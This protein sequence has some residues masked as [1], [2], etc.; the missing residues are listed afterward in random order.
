[1]L[2]TTCVATMLDGGPRHQRPAAAGARANVNCRI[3][4]G[5]PAEEVRQTLQKLVDDPK[6][7][8]TT[9]G[10]RSRGQQR[11]PPPLTP[12]IMKSDRDGRRRRCGRACRCIPVLQTGATDGP[13]PHP[14]AGIP[15]YGVSRACSRDPD[16]NGVH[17][18]N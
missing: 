4:P 15:T 5:V 1:M 16:G 9:L 11:P 10:A 2:R 12:E 13:L 17:G 6:V 7:T 8:V 18:L 14:L 3:F